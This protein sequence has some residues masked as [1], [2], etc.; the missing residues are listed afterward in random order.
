MTPTRPL[1]SNIVRFS[2]VI[3]LTLVAICGVAVASVW[4]NWSNLERFRSEVTIPVDQIAHLQQSLNRAQASTVVAATT[5]SSSW[6]RRATADRL[7][8][9]SLLETID[10]TPSTERLRIR[11]AQS[12]AALTQWQLA[13]ES[14][15]AGDTSVQLLSTRH[16]AEASNQLDLLARDLA[17]IRAEQRRQI[18]QQAALGG[19]V[20]IG[21]TATAL[22]SLVVFTARTSHRLTDPLEK[23][24]VDVK[25]HMTADTAARV[26]EAQG[27]QEASDL[28]SA[29]N[30]L[31]DARTALLKEQRRTIAAHQLAERVA[32]LLANTGPTSSTIW[33]GA[34]AHL[35]DV[36]DLEGVEV[37]DTAN[38]PQPLLLAS[39]PVDS[40]A[41]AAPPSTRD[42]G[43]VLHTGALSVPLSLGGL[44]QGVLVLQR[45]EP[46]PEHWL[47]ALGTVAS[48]CADAVAVSAIVER[49]ERLDRDKSDFMASTSH[50]LRTPLTS[51]IAW[52]GIL[53]EGELG[54][55]NGKQQQALGVVQRNAR[56]LL[57]LI[58]DMLVLHR[59]DS[60]R[61]GIS[62]EKVC[63]RDV[64]ASV[65]ESLR[66]LAEQKSV[67]LS[68][69]YAIDV[70]QDVI[71]GDRGQIER[72]ITNIV[73]NAIKFTPSGGSVTLT[74][75]AKTNHVVIECSDTGIGI[76]SA[77]IPR[78]LERFHRSQNASDHPGTG[79]G[80]AI[81]AS[82]VEAH[83]GH[84]DIQS[85]EGEGTHISVALPRRTSD[86]AGR[87]SA[88]RA[89]R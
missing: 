26:N 10:I 32:E 83:G 39:W 82:I 52:L 27:F 88:R 11:L 78:V 28:A 25:E 59:L 63:L 61:G 65:T 21:V 22:I 36:L 60:G 23:L 45:S 51:M 84:I 76:P 8:A 41:T 38:Y 67:T 15:V 62:R 81:V 80:L 85:T 66:P 50:E 4:S 71:L 57:S 5:G 54:P 35:S 89:T 6:E 19:A 18:D 40:P 43:R 72:A 37:W 44:V 47:D 79:L 86:A 69:C 24:V 73:N 2:M 42:T 70:G 55:L 48:H 31:S 77:D 13:A 46:M 64:T 3:A 53:E 1:A 12:R 30:L 74:I 87:E 75:L 16:F 29:I 17:A 56:R 14:T 68:A 49:A 20:I 58:E 33:E 7:D 34:L 9:T